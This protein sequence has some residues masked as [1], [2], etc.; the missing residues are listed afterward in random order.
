MFRILEVLWVAYGW[1]SEK[2]VPFPIVLSCI[3][4]VWEA[5]GRTDIA[6]PQRDV[7]IPA[8]KPECRREQR[9]PLT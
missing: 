2:A 7:Q 8:V 5:E 1:H 3:L 4:L 6:S 9:E